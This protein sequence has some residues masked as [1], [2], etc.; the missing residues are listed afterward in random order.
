ME[1]LDKA[2]YNK[3][4]Q[5][6]NR[7]TINNL[8]ARA[9]VEQKIS[10]KIYVDDQINPETFYIVHPYGMSLLFGKCDNEQFN[11]SFESYALNLDNSRSSFEWMQAFPDSWDNVLLSLFSDA[12]V[13]SSDNI[14]KIEKRI[15]ELNTRVNFKF[16]ISKH[17]SLSTQIID[18]DITIVRADGKMFSDMQGSVIPS[19]FWNSENDFLKNGLAYA[20]Y[21][22]EELAAMSFSSFCFDNIIEL[23][24]ETK[25][26]FRGKGLAEFVCRAIID[27][28]V[29]N[30]Y[31][32]V[33]A[34]RLE[35]TGSY[36][37]AQKL[38]FEPT[39]YLPYYRLSK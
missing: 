38:G 25:E 7:V 3:I 37:L 8:F 31:E 34:C 24:I 35:N 16:N 11:K 32:P 20:L 19:Y 17:Q 36:K 18:K 22:K 39:L 4:V 2:Y 23:G 29:E 10:G 5:P 15:V 28:C 27:Y 30:N 26:K 14:D 6:L 12:S 13:K 9:V 21:Y 33:W 1:L